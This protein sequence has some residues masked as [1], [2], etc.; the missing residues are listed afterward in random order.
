MPKFIDF[1]SISAAFKDPEFV[2]SDFAKFDR[3]QQLHLGFQALHA[4]RQTTRPSPRPLS[5][6]D[7]LAVLAIHQ[8][9]G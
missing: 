8:E 5:E 3:P 7:A 4:F 1:Q 9:A 6:E 2:I